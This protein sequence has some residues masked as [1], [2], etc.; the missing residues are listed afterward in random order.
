MPEAFQPAPLLVRL[1]MAAGISGAAV[2]LR[3]A[4]ARSMAHHLYDGEFA[5]LG[6]TALH[7]DDGSFHAPT[8]SQFIHAT[9]YMSYGQ[10]TMA[11]SLGTVAFARVMGTH[12]GALQATTIAA[13]ALTLF[14][15]VLLLSRVA[16]PLWCAAAVL[17]WIFAPLLAVTWQLLPFGNHSE[18]LW[19]PLGLAWFVAARDPAERPV[20]HWL[21]PLLLA[22]LGLWLYRLNGAGLIAFV[23]VACWSRSWRPRLLAGVVAVV[24]GVTVVLAFRAL[25][26]HVQSDTLV[27]AFEPS[28]S[29]IIDGLSR[30]VYHLPRV[31]GDLDRP[32]AAVEQTALL[33]AVPVTATAWLRRPDPAVRL[34]RFA[35]LWGLVALVGPA[36]AIEQVPPRYFINAF[37]AILLCLGALLAG[38]AG[39]RLRW[40]AL[41][42]AMALAGVGAV[43]GAG[44]VDRSVWPQTREL[45]SIRLW[46]GAGVTAIDLDEIRYWSRIVEEGRGDRMTGWVSNCPTS[47]CAVHPLRGGVIRP[48][49]ESCRGFGPGELAPY[50]PQLLQEQPEPGDP[51]VLESAGRGIWIRAQRDTEQA[52]QALE[53]LPEDQIEQIMRGVLDEARRWTE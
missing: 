14:V 36:V 9:T 51:P 22:T 46:D 5:R 12:G 10:G 32:W 38:G 29:A 21:L 34:A 11:T 1:A 49:E 6:R 20:W 25:A 18:F 43:D 15:L 19:V 47:R 4:Q 50:V 16:R 26:G 41:A 7:M 42:A 13:E 37:Y 24:A 23:G 45:D 52:R 8:V 39:R 27:P 53:G 44:W 28:L 17:P 30:A 2:A 35:S 48:A 31:P 40:P 33:L 3:A